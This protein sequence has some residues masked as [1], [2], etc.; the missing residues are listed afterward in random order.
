MS[1]AR[2][3]PSARVRWFEKLTGGAYKRLVYQARTAT[4]AKAV[5]QVG[6][7]TGFPHIEFNFVLT[8]PSEDGREGRVIDDVRIYMTLDEA[9][10]FTQHAIHALDAATPR[11]PRPARNS[12]YDAS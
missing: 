12:P 1:R 3:R 11:Q 2:N 6:D 5:M 7:N 4:A 8:M 9:S 10:K